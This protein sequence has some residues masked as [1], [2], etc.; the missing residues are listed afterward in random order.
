MKSRWQHKG[1]LL[2]VD[3]KNLEP[4]VIRKING[5]ESSLDIYTEIS[6]TLDFEVDRVIIKRGIIST[7]WLP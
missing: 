6:N 2:Y 5:K 7:L 4:R 3:F 1:E